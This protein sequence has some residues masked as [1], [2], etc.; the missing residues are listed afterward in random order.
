MGAEQSINIAIIGA[1]RGGTALIE[2]F[3]RCHGIAITGIADTSQDAPGLRLARNL[4]IPATTDPDNKML[5]GYGAN[6]D[7]YETWTTN[8]LPT[9]DSQQPFVGEYPLNGYPA[10]P[11]VRNKDTGFLITGQVA[12][13]QAVHTG[14]DVPLSAFGHGASLFTG[15]MDNTDVFF[16][17]AQASIG[18]LRGESDRGGDD[19]ERCR[20]DKD[21]R[22]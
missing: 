11:N 17:I 14:S 10:N 19:R 3:T 7:R 21:G 20:R 2:L 5:I 12:G 15:V 4:N 22:D 16:K 1:G 8:P 6:A 13:E 9:Q 18:G